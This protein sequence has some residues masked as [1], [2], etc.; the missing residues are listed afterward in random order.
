MVNDNNGPMNATG[1]KIVTMV[2]GPKIIEFYKKKYFFK[3]NV[4]V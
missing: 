3:L 1:N 2:I 4:H